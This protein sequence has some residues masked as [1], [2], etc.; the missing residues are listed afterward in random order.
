MNLFLITYLIFSF[1]SCTEV[2]TEERTEIKRNK[3]DNSSKNVP[4]PIN[5]KS[6]NILEGVKSFISGLFFLMILVL[7]QSYLFF[8]KVALKLV[9][10]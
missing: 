6:C 2:V 10:F 3:W 8:R 9:Y 5:K 1:L 7:Y 4:A